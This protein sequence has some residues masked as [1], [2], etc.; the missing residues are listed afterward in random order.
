VCSF[1]ERTKLSEHRVCICRA[2]KTLRTPFVHLQSEQNS[3]NTVC[4][5]A[6][7]TKLSEHRVF[8][9]RANKTLRTPCVHLQREQNSQNTVCS[10]PER[11]K[12]SEHHVF[13]CPLL[14]F[15][16]VLTLIRLVHNNTHGK[17]YPRRRFPF[18]VN[19]L[20]CVGFDYYSL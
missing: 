12:L 11:T 14:H 20:K 4:A 18:T 3:Q 17:M 8:I 5:F 2:N 19:T 10:F 15:S 13:I 16:A 9:F 7:R 1:S 6:E